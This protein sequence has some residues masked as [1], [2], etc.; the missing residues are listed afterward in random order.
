V[1]EIDGP[2]AWADLCG[3]FPLEVTASRRH[4]W[5]RATG[6]AGRWVVPDWSRVAR[7]VDAV[8]LSVAGYLTTAGRAIPVGDDGASV[9]AGWDPDQT[10][11]LSDVRPDPMSRRTWRYDRDDDDWAPVA[12]DA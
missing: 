2:E 4:N 6:R 3:R 7:H 9:L 5:Y 11:W 12:P 8:H 10:F 1:L